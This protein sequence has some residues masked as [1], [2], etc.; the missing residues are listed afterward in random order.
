MRYI[1]LFYKLCNIILP[2]ILLLL[3]FLLLLII[4][5]I[6]IIS[7]YF[8]SCLYL[9]SLFDVHLPF[10]QRANKDKMEI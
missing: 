2:K 5:I 10:Q 4:V 6:F 3:L 9:L 1:P 7:P 8:S